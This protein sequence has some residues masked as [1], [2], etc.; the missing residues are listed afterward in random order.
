MASPSTTVLGPIQ[1]GKF[2]WPFAASMLD[3]E[4]EGYKEAE[5]FLEGEAT[6]YKL[7]AG[8]EQGREA[9]WQAETAGTAPFKTRFI[10]YLPAEPAKFN[11][12]VILTWNNVTAGHDLF[13]ADSRELFESGFALVCLTTQKAG[14]DGLPPIHQGLAGWDEQRYPDLNIPSDDYSFDIFSQAAE[15]LGPN[16]QTGAIDPM[17]GLDVKRVIA[18]GASQSA[19][20]LATFINAIAPIHNPFDGFI[21]QIYFGRGTPLEVGDTVVNISAPQSGNPADRLRG[22]NLLRDDLGVPVF[23]VNSELEATAGY[24]V[25]QPDTDTMRCWEVAGTSHTSVQGRVIRQKL[26]D[27]D[28]LVSNKSDPR[29]NAISIGPVYDAVYHHMQKWLA[30]GIAPPLLPRINFEGDTPMPVRDELGIA[31]GGIRL[32]QAEVPLG[33]NSAIPLNEDIF[34]LLGGSCVPF[35]K[36]KALSLYGDKESFIG[37][38]DEARDAA[39]A[40]GAILPRTLEGLTQQAGE[41]WDSIC[42][43][44]S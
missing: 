14:I 9:S 41:L 17:S 32:P 44:E 11:G 2:G 20:R 28:K 6:R 37:R 27:R 16:R 22:T 25:R 18:Q 33:R 34:A 39:L 4:N 29:I 23:V 13:Q 8:T 38:F 26:L 5:Y 10:V 24:A 42:A 19:G 31:T 40:G 35:D 15:V 21:L 3:M 36:E 30:D 12:T 43:V 1:G 7:V